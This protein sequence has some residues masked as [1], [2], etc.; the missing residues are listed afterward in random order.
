MYQSVP[1]VYV[2]ATHQFL[3]Q[4]LSMFIRDLNFIHAFSALSRLAQGGILRSMCSSST[5]PGAKPFG[6]WVWMP[7][8][9][10]RLV[11]GIN[12]ASAVSFLP[13][14]FHLRQPIIWLILSHIS[15]SFI[16]NPHPWAALSFEIYPILW[17]KLA[18]GPDRTHPPP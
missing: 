9:A 18:S 5:P 11:L 7:F 8:L 2:Q 17:M 6:G 12:L 3:L 13:G 14:C 4:M 15:L 10:G 1:D 16:L